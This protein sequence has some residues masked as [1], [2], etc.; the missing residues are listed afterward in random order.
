MPLHWHKDISFQMVGFDFIKFIRI[1]LSVKWLDK[2]YTM[3]DYENRIIGLFHMPTV[4]YCL[5]A[6]LIVFSRQCIALK[7]SFYF[8]FGEADTK[9]NCPVI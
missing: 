8:L 7:V 3:P 9:R 2:D 4:L 1:E 6:M 5:Y